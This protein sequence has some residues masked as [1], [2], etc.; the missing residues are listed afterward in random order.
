[1]GTRIKE[2]NGESNSD[3]AIFSLL[4]CFSFDSLLFLLLCGAELARKEERM[5]EKRG[6]KQTQTMNLRRKKHPESCEKKKGKKRGSKKLRKT[7]C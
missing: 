4:F 5:K 7:S 2:K 3:C 1:M 6:E